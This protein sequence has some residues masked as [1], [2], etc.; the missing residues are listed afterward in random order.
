LEI[1]AVIPA[2]G[3]SKGLPGKNIKPLCGKP[4]LAYSI[5]AALGAG[6]ITRVMVNTEDPAIAEVARSCG[7]EVPFLRPA[8]LAT[9]SALIS[10]A[11]EYMLTTLADGRYSP[12]A[13]VV[14]SPT[15]PFRTPSL[16]DALVTRLDQGYGHVSSVARRRHGPRSVFS[17]RKGLLQ[18]LLQEGCAEPELATLTF[19]RPTGLLQGYLRQPSKNMPTYLHVLEDPIF[20]V[21]IDTIEDFSL[22]EAIIQARLF[23][24]ITGPQA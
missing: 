14:L 24:F 15:H 21:D 10:E 20:D 2:R 19:F 18:P 5:E 23:D 12:E 6:S 17:A 4:L 8:G 22:A 9:D 13:V 3:G 7:A 16:V 11:I 1:L